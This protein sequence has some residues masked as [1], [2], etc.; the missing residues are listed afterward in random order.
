MGWRWPW[1]KAEDREAEGGYTGII[2]QLV[3]LQAA[4]TTQQ[5]SATAAME[6][7][8]GALSRAFMGAVVEAHPTTSPRP[9]LRAS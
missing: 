7:A 2:S 1:A 6:A 8:A 4:G 9:C 3:E 5:A